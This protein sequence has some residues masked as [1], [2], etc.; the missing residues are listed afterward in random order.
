VIAGGL[1]APVEGLF[2]GG[3]SQL[4]FFFLF[5]QFIKVLPG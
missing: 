3:Q 5:G 4:T 1:N 2:Y